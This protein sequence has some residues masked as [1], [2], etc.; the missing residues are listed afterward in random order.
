LERRDARITSSP[1]A[2][3]PCECGFVGGAGPGSPLPF[4]SRIDRGIRQGK[5]REVRSRRG[6]AFG[7]GREG[8][9]AHRSKS[10]RCRG[11]TGRL[12]AFWHPSPGARQRL[13]FGW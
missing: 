9:W 3:S 8:F 2:A 11:V 4:P 13:V 6:A 10:R 5:Q 7:P 1:F 12:A